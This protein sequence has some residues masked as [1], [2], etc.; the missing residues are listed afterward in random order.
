MTPALAFK[1][2]A[3]DWRAGELRLLVA[4]LLVAVGSVSAISLFVDRLQRAIE[5]ES[6]TFL[7]A[8]RVI[9]GSKVI[10]E[11]FRDLAREKGLEIADVVTFNSMVFADA[12]GSDRNQLA[13]VKAVAPGYPLRG[14]V[15]IAN[16][17]FVRGT[18]TTEVPALG[19]VWMDSRLFPA[20]GVD[21]G[22]KVAVGY[23]EFTVSAVLTGEPDRGGSF[24]DF[25]PRV[26]MRAEDIPATRVV[27]PGS[28]IGYR[29][30]LAGDDGDLSALFR[31]VRPELAPDF[32]WRSIRDANES[33][34]RALDRA[35]SFLLL[36]GMLAVL[37][38][39][40]A[41]ALA[42]NRYAR[43]HFDHVG[44]L[45]TLGAT[46]MDIQWGYF[47]VLLVI[48]VAGT[49]LGLVL[50]GVVHLGII[51]ALGDLLPATLPL[52]GTRPL[53]V[54][55]ITG[56][57]CLLAFAL[58]PLLGLKKISP[59][60]VIRR[61]LGPS[62]APIVT[63]GFATG[64]SLALLIWH[65]GSVLLTV[66]ALIGA[67]ITGG[68]FAILAL[69]LLRGGRVIGMQAG[70]TWRLALAGLQRRYREN[71]AQ[72]VIFGFAIMLLL[73]MLLV[74]TALVDDWQ[75]EIPERTPNHFLIN[76]APDEAEAV[77]SLLTDRTDYDGSLFAMI[78][79]RIS[80][81]NDTPAKDWRRRYGPGPGVRGER[82]LTF[83]RELPA[84]NVVIDGEWWNTS[85]DATVPPAA[86][87]EADYARGIGVGIGD[88]LTFEVGGLPLTVTVTNIRSVEW[89]SL[90]PN[91]YIIFS[92]GALDGYPATFMTSFYLPRE[93]KPF[94]NDLL[95]A[96]PTVTLIEVDEI[97]RQV[98]SIIDRVTQ[99]V[100]LVL[101]LVL[102]AGILVLIASIGSSRDQRLR[103]HA[104]LRALGGTRQLIQGALVAEFAILGVFAGLVAVI[105]AE[106]TV[107]T[108]NR[109]IFE[110]PTDL[111]PW[112]WAA[113]PGLGVAM[114]ATVGYLGTRKLVRSPP[115]TVL[116][117]V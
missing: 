58:P 61:D 27:Q 87:L 13:S 14:V 6:T 9:G 113:G 95:A 55:A 38:A 34:G 92:P 93:Q 103:E 57:I 26:L 51:A 50:G 66:A 102:G 5:V 89:D 108:L 25:G 84:N 115:A 70:S 88:E 73:V 71:V 81:I 67:V 85:E 30:M 72:I 21:I 104:L 112:L 60:R 17:P 82:N 1:F 7:G 80:A 94:L 47:G 98:R 74:R 101:Y 105:G 4:A 12:S 46:P 29:L 97:I 69:V 56:L 33:I 77:Q 53:V 10:P 19:E 41:V 91:F 16:E 3:R 11:H 75:A 40:I 68:T 42:A 83:S 31:E 109:Q 23:A 90:Q 15:R 86:S 37:L 65:S 2:A 100:E 59:M 107:Y 54:G 18:P 44:V 63:Y 24:F 99:T 79:G 45:K 64:G 106:I 39:G 116:R 76:V 117:E 22:E 52:P 78:R 28:R 48:G 36:G 20:L 32:R 43:R 49:L 35:E 111:H 62:V 110:L 114:I 8:D 96:H